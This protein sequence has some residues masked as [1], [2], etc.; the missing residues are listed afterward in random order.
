MS[1]SSVQPNAAYVQI[2]GNNMI[3]QPCYINMN[4]DPPLLSGS[5]IKDINENSTWGLRTDVYV[6]YNGQQIRNYQME[7]LDGEITVG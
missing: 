7:D 4:T 3:S 6:L 5:E 1:Y 2:Y